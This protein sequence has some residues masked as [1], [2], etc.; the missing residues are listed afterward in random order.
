MLEFSFR[1]C[2]ATT[3]VYLLACLAADGPSLLAAQQQPNGGEIDVTVYRSW[4]P[5]DVTMVEG[6]FWVRPAELGATSEDGCPYSVELLVRDDESVLV[7]EEWTGDCP[8]SEGQITE[9]AVLETF[10]FGLRP[11]TYTVAVTVRAG[12]ERTVELEVDGYSGSP[13]ASDM[14]LARHVDW[15]DSTNVD[16]WTLRR[17]DLGIVTAPDVVV[18]P[19][20]PSLS[21]YIELYVE[22][23]DRPAGELSAAILDQQ[24]TTLH[25][26]NLAEFEESG[27]SRPLTGSMSLS[28]LPPGEYNLEVRLAV[29]DT[30]IEQRHEFHMADPQP[31]AEEGQEEATGYYAELGEEEL[32]ELF[33]PLVLWIDSERVREQYRDLSPDA[34]RRFLQQYFEGATPTGDAD[35]EEPIDIYLARVRRANDRYGESTGRRDIAAWETDRGEIYLLRG[36]PDEE[37]QRPLPNSGS[38]Y[39]IWSFNIGRGYVYLFVDESGMGNYSLVLSTDPE[40]NTEPGWQR[41]VGGEAIAELRRFGVRDEF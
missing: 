7:E 35:S 12:E 13:V 27:E 41:L 14:V 32:S 2:L 36:R 22:E 16:D 34:R 11:G 6:L 18:E 8:E 23:E 21:Y 10:R 19:E 28:G 20:D 39:E 25:T 26:V 15:V 40:Y 4:R 5:P 17:G 24:G 9:A 37:V 1:R 29:G 33:D 3:V 38:P 31:V 30:V